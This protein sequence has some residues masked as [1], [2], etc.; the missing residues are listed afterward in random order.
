M[1]SKGISMAMDGMKYSYGITEHT[2]FTIAIA[3]AY[4]AAVRALSIENEALGLTESSWL[5]A[6]QLS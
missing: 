4:H 1:D 5:I 3:L 6:L 2:Q